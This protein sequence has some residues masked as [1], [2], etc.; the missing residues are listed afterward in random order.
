M[1]RIREISHA[2]ETTEILC[3]YEDRNGTIWAG[4]YGGGINK[5][6]DKSGNFVCYRK[7]DGLPDNVVYG[8]LEDRSGFLWLSTNRG[9]SRFDP[10]KEIFRNFDVH[11]GLQSNEFNSG[12]FYKS[13]RGEFFFGGINGFNAFYPENIESDPNVPPVIFTDFQISP[14]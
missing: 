12:S 10:E 14:L 6:D 9:L 11:D 4:T 7:E 13:K 2:I 8:I 5:F 3:V 1:T